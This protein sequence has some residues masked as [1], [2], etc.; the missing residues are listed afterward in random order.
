METL[1]VQMRL[2]RAWRE[3]FADVDVVVMPAFGVPA[4]EHQ[5]N[6]NWM[7]RT[8][9]VNGETTL[10]GRQLFWPGVATY[11]G[12]PSTAVPVTKSKDGLPI[13]VQVMGNRYDDRTTL[14]FAALAQQA[15]FA[16]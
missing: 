15:G 16:K 9:V 3:I 6:P 12:L 8:L 5:D 14:T 11:P 1:D 4:F 2:A 7:E 13:G 10:Y